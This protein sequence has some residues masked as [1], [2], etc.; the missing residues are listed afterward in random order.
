MTNTVQT[1]TDELL[2]ALIGLARA[3]EG[4]EFLLTPATDVCMLR[5]LIAAANGTAEESVVCLAD[6]TAEK[7]RL[8][9]D[10]FRC[11]APCGRTEDYNVALLRRIHTPSAKQRLQLLDGICTL[12]ARFRQRSSTDIPASLMRFFRYALYAVG[13][14]SW[15]EQELEP[16]F[17]ELATAKKSLID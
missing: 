12:A 3:T 13:M 6:V 4:N 11:G 7:R 1:T 14:D 16:I 5:A 8:V 9:P 2:G 17:A 15:T 10:C